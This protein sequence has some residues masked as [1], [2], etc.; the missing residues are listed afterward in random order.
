M[1][2]SRYEELTVKRDDV[3]LTHAEADELGKLMADR[4]GA[5]YENAET[6][7]AQGAEPFPSGEQAQ[8]EPCGHVGCGCTT[9]TPFCSDFCRDHMQEPNEAGPAFDCG[10]GHD[11]C[12]AVI[13][14]A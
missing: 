4:E 12:R 10:C 14:E 5:E 6:L 9:S 13:G 3:G 2:A 8:G 11:Q 1:D 7:R